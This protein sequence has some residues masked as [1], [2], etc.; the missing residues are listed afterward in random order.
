MSKREPGWTSLPQF[1]PMGSRGDFIFQDIF[2][3]F[4]IV[5]YNSLRYNTD[6]KEK[7]AI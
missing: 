4:W 6:C 5:W 1:L 7:S 3:G 2:A